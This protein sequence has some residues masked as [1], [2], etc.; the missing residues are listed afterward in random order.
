MSDDKPIEL[1][2]AERRIKASQI[3]DLG[4]PKI[5]TVNLEAACSSLL[6]TLESRPVVSNAEAEQRDDS[7]SVLK[8]RTVWNAPKR[9]VSK[10]DLDRSVDGWNNAYDALK[11]KLGSGFT[12]ALVGKRGPGKTQIAVELM[13]EATAR[14]RASYYCTAMDYFSRIKDGFHSD[15]TERLRDAQAFFVKPLLLV[16]DEIHVRSDSAWEDNMLIDLI[17]KRYNAVLDTILISNQTIEEFERSI[18]PSILDRL[19]ETGG[20]IEANWRSFRA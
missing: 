6:S 17:G 16:L 13:R 12:V 15:R 7:A 11:A 10:A 1:L 14:L 4:I 8:L 3:G 20:I 18:G 9:H 2:E 5:K 19:N